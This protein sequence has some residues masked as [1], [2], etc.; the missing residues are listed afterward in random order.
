MRGREL[1]VLDIWG[2]REPGHDLEAVETALLVLLGSP[3]VNRRHRK[4]LLASLLRSER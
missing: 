2:Q 4:Q 1:D 3:A